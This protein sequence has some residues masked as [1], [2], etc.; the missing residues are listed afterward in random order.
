MP[1]QPAINTLLATRQA[2]SQLM[3]DE[4]KLGQARQTEQRRQQFQSLA[5]AIATGNRDA[6]EQGI[7][8]AP[9]ETKTMLDILN[10]LE[11]RER[12]DA[13]NRGERLSNLAAGVLAAPEAQRADIYRA[14]RARAV[15]ISP[16]LETA[17]PPGYTPD[18]DARLQAFR[19][20]FVDAS[21]RL[22]QPGAVINLQSPTGEIVGLRS[23][24][25]QV[26]ELLG[27]GYTRAPIRQETGEPG[28]FA[29]DATLIRE[30]GQ[31]EVA[32]RN[33]L[34]SAQQL[35]DLIVENPEAL[36]ATARGVSVAKAL[37]TEAET[38]SEVLGIPFDSKLTDPDTFDSTFKELGIDSRRA[39]S[40]ITGLAFAAAASAGQTGR[41]VSDRDVRLF[42]E[43]AGG[44]WASP[45]ERI[46]VLTDLMT[47]IE[48]NF[49]NRHQV[50]LGRPFEGDLGIVPLEGSTIEARDFR[51]ATLEELEAL[52]LGDLSEQELDAAER[53][54]NELNRAQR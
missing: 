25:P 6:I 5:P 34:A 38:L 18:V 43:R 32:T 26:N 11:D 3:L 2:R 51:N 40:I 15:E 19:D 14:N 1:V 23:D 7:Q 49:R 10:D 21:S 30:L 36:S 12:D 9:E 31:A 48:R 37:V 46:A 13:M 8:V 44:G 4:Y 27:Q 33:A 52:D 39:Q 28:A 54:F 35:R 45:D 47:E 50:T 17:L 29:G 22:R 24:D 41:S 42:I 20:E 53:R 16:D